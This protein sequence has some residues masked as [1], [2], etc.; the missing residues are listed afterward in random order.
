MTE[1]EKNA[2]LPAGLRDV[3][4]VDAALEAELVERIVS[5]FGRNGYER[6]KPPIIEFEDSLLSG[7]GVALTSPQA[8]SSTVVSVKTGMDRAYRRPHGQGSS[9]MALGL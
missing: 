2:L 8:V 3:L 7:A 4:P 9:T 6:I 1:N 5:F